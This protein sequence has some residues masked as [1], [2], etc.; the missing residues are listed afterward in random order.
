M[1]KVLAV[2]LAGVMALTMFGCKKESNN[3]AAVSSTKA[4]HSNDVRSYLTGQWVSKE[5]NDKRPIA[6]MLSNTPD[7]PKQ[8][9]VGRASVIYEA[10]GE[11]NY[12]T[13]LMGIF[14]DWEDIEKMG[15][16]RSCRTYYVYYM[17]E[18]DA[19]YVH[20]GQAAYALP[21]LEKEFVDNLSTLRSEASKVFFQTDD[22]PRPHNTYT[23]GK[24]IKEGAE[25]MKYNLYHNSSY[26][27]HYK[28][29]TDDENMVT[30]D[31]GQ[32]A[33]VVK[34]GYAV[35]KP[36]FVYDEEKGVYY[37]YQSED[38]HIDAVTNE[39]LSVSNIIIQYSKIGNYDDTHYWN[40]DCTSGG[41]GK[42]ITNGKAIDITWK[43]HSEFGITHY[44]DSKGKE[45]TLNQGKTWVCIVDKEYTEKTEILSSKDDVDSKGNTV[46]KDDAKSSS[47]SSNT[48]KKN[49]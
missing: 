21:T 30:P 25:Y 22:R 3:T 23:S 47:S 1:K 7:A 20:A 44:Y 36:W 15:S 32:T 46:K 13:R 39:Q 43:K 19:I 5:V 10:P 28:F 41:K 37:R 2:I 29:N 42:F 27:E 49:N 17:L 31:G 34:P 16:I 45:I 33:M 9:G 40:I 14:E 26:K 18:F 12:A 6:V 38:K 8:S 24:G 35:N 48:K 11:G 4:D